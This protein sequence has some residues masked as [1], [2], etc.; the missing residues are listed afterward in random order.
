MAK[1]KK[2]KVPKRVAGVK[3]PKKLRKRANKA[4]AIADNP[5]AHKLAVAALTAAAASLARPPKLSDGEGGGEV[6]LEAVKA[7]AAKLSDLVIAAAL[8]GARRLL[9]GIETPAAQNDDGPPRR[10]RSNGG[11]APEAP[12]PD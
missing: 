12:E 8:E 4:L 5:A 9:E 2:L 11:P 10:P 3:V 7:Q 1:E 6:N